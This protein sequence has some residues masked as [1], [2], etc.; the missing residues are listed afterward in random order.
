YITKMDRNEESGVETPD[1]TDLCGFRIAGISRV[2][3]ASAPSTMTG[4]ADQAPTVYFAVSV[5]TPRPGAQL[6]RRVML[7]DQLH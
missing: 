2:S 7:V 3:V 1:M 6:V 4:D 5:Q